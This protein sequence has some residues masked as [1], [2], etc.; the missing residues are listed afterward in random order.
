MYSEVVY[1]V[2]SRK[3][4]AREDGVPSSHPACNLELRWPTAESKPVG[5]NKFMQHVKF[6]MWNP[7]RFRILKSLGKRV[8]AGT[9]RDVISS[10]SHQH[11]ES[12]RVR[13]W[14]DAC[15]SRADRACRELLIWVALQRTRTVPSC[16]SDSLLVKFRYRFF[17]C[18]LV[19]ET[20]AELCIC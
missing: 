5:P 19:Y 3:S 18:S 11:G 14:Y 10:Q 6:K 16:T 20:L 13:V 2:T 12:S 9:A 4:N 17:M 15:C 1:D 8:C 7:M